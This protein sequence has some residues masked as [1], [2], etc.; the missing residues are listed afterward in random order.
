MLEIV[1]F[2]ATVI[3]IGALARK[4]GS[5]P[6][7]W[8]LAAAVGAF[9]IAFIFAPIVNSSVIRN[10][11]LPNLTVFIPTLAAW[12]WMGIVAVYVRFGIGVGKPQPQGMW[13]CP[14]C[15]SL[16]QQHALF[17]DACREPWSD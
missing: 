2:I 8:P 3:G 10:L 9:A 1:A 12:S 16:N 7:V 13:T 17:C 5:S 11:E 14:E 4:R 6:I 15:K